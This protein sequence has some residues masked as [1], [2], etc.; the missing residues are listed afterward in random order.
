MPTPSR[1]QADRISELRNLLNKANHAYYI[2]DT[3]L[4]EDAVFDRLYRELLELEKQNPSLIT[5]DSPSQRLGGRPSKGF[6]SVKHRIPLQSLDNAFNITELNDWYSRI[7]KLHANNSQLVCELKID[8][9]AVALSY[10]NGFLQTG[11]TRGDGTEGEEI[12]PNVKTIASIPLSLHLKNPP[13]WLEVRGEAF[14]PNSTFQQIN[15]LRLKEGKQI[16]ANPRNACSG[17]LRQL[18]PRVVAAR[19]L[20]FFAYTIHLPEDW[21]PE[22]TEPSKPKG[23]WE[24]LQWLKT[25]GFK[26]NPNTQL[27]NDIKAV[28]AFCS[29]WESN[30]HNMPYATDGVVVKI[31][32]FKIQNYV[33]TTNKAPR[34]A[35][36]LK[37]PA[38]EAPTI[39]KKLTFQ[40]GRTGAITP[41]AEFK[42]ISL[43]GTLVSRATLHNAKRIADLDIHSGDTIV[44][45]K[46]GEI[47]PE[48]VRVIK[49][50]RPEETNKLF[51]PE[52]CPECNSKL[53]QEATEAITKC[54]NHHCPAILRGALRHWVSKGAMNI[55][56]FGSKLIEQLVK[57]NLVKSIADLYKLN[58]K[59]IT[60]LER[61]GEKSGE[62]LLI[63]IK[64]SKN[65]PWHK[66]L[67]ALGILHIGEANAKA[68]AK[69]FPSASKLDFSLK[70]S[71][72]SIS[73]IF[74]IGEEI[75]DSLQNWF[76][77]A[78]NQQLIINLQKE[79]ISFASNQQ[80]DSLEINQV[81]RI[82]GDMI[83]IT[84]TLESLSREQAKDMIESAGGK[85][86][87]SVSSKTTFLVAGKKSGSKYKKAQELGVKIIN[88]KELMNLLKS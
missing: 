45:R 36:A 47:I 83:V 26:V 73:K 50:L 27:M 44:I 55:D 82:S 63:A 14:I 77:T 76:N 12:T 53:I 35:I 32:N 84:G 25:A 66:Q 64:N 86:T 3:P 49:D 18:D 69:V 48:V 56:G 43:A 24:A 16:F 51:L 37:Y 5:L 40:V 10:I 13:P 79:G 6:Q 88:E 23:Q 68:I 46:A 28:T 58:K 78:S 72:E 70:N 7:D 81:T 74:G 80:E 61:M 11:A 17:T 52:N 34:W 87:N 62:K 33:G 22:E 29:E 9:N 54:T 42:P 65:Q 2:L 30:R 41:V 19:R 57:K 59:S 20:D 39:L 31:E 8:G 4:I 15:A 75:L 38:E 85:V 67:Y 60:N 1:N 71:P 21:E